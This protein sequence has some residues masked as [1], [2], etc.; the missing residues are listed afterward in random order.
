MSKLYDIEDAFV[1][2]HGNLQ[3]NMV[4]LITTLIVIIKDTTFNIRF[5]YLRVLETV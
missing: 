5:P 4:C 2:G 3:K 1:D